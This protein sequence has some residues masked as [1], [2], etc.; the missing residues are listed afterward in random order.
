MQ[1]TELDA[2]LSGSGYLVRT[3]CQTTSAIIQ[4]LV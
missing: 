4:P 2:E 3:L 1:T